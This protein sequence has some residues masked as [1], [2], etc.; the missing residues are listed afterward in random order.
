MVEER[1]RINFKE[2]FKKLF[3]NDEEEIDFE[4]EK[5]PGIENWEE[6]QKSYKRTKNMERDIFSSRIIEK[7]KV[8]KRNPERKVTRKR[9]KDIEKADSKEMEL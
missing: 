9:A 2:L 4:N 6:L 8:A 1:N 5:N 3:G 7:Q